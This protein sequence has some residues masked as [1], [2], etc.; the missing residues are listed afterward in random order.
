MRR[1]TDCACTSARE[2]CSIGAV[3]L[4]PV[5]MSVVCDWSEVFIVP[6]PPNLGRKPLCDNARCRGENRTDYSNFFRSK[7]QVT[8]PC[9]GT[10][11]CVAHCLLVLDR[12]CHRVLRLCR[13]LYWN[14]LFCTV[15]RHRFTGWWAV[16]LMDS[17]SHCP[18]PHSHSRCDK[19]PVSVK[20][21]AGR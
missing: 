9:D 10:V 20:S 8:C 17:A 3:N 11:K 2:V 12:K 15:H 18:H 19:K 14:R 7:P 16:D 1:V 6:I 21:R 13:G 4:M 5:A